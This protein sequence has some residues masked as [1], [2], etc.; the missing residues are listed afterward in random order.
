MNLFHILKNK[1]TKRKPFIYIALGDS[2]VEGVGAS[3]PHRAY[4]GILHTIVKERKRNTS[5]HNLGIAGATVRNVIDLQLKKA[6][7]L[8]PDLVTISVGANDIKYRTTTKRF[9][10][11]MKFLL[12]ELQTKTNANIIVNTIPDLSI[13]PAIPRYLKSYSRFM[14]IRFNS[15]ISKVGEE[16]SIPIV[17]LF[18]YS[19]SILRQFP[20]A[21][22]SDGFHPSDFGY[23]IWA[24]TMIPHI[25]ALTSPS[26]RYYGI[27]FP[28]I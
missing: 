11:E 28:F 18:N 24:N 22:A 26:R 9:K 23:A 20:E 7:E 2:T 10:S 15:S 19:R 21:I 27:H 8:Q 3:A 17:D 13:T 12:E 25:H 6:I 4:T 14:A 1:V 5:Y 16:L